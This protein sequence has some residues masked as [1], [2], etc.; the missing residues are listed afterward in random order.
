VNELEK[1]KF[2]QNVITLDVSQLV[3]II[4]KEHYP[5]WQKEEACKD[6]KKRGETHES[7]RDL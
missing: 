6:L 7:C 4:E 1:R 2:L 3:W 5:A